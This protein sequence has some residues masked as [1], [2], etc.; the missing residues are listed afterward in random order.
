MELTCRRR[1]WPSCSWRVALVAC[2]RGGVVRFDVDVRVVG[3][4]EYDRRDLATGEL[5]FE[6]ARHVRSFY[7]RSIACATCAS[8][9]WVSWS[10]CRSGWASK[11]TLTI[12]PVNLAPGAYSSV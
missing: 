7:W 9:W 6:H 5:R 2:H 1:R 10:G 4:V 3:D 12:L 11:S 8:A